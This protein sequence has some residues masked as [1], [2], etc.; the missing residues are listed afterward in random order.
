MHNDDNH[1]ISH[2]SR[3]ETT[4]ADAIVIRINFFIEKLSKP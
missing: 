4:Q 1:F 2:I 3:F